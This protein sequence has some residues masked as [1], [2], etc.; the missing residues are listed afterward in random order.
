MN[1]FISMNT[2]LE[3]KNKFSDSNKMINS[4]NDE[5]LSLFKPSNNVFIN[6][7]D[8]INENTLTELNDNFLQKNQNNYTNE[9]SSPLLYDRNIVSTR[10]NDIDDI[11]VSTINSNTSNIPPSPS[12]NINN[13]IKSTINQTKKQNDLTSEI[14]LKNNKMY[15]NEIELEKKKIENQKNQLLIVNK[16]LQQKQL[17]LTEIETNFKKKNNEIIILKKQL[18]DQRNHY[19]NETENLKKKQNTYDQ[20][21]IQKKTEYD[22]NLN[23]LKEQQKKNQLDRNEIQSQ[24]S[25]LKTKNQSIEENEKKLEIEQ[26]K[27]KLYFNKLI[28]EKSEISR[29]YKKNLVLQKQISDTLSEKQKIEET[30]SA[31]I[32]LQDSQ[33][34]SINIEKNELDNKKKEYEQTKLD[35]NKLITIIKNKIE[36]ESIDDSVINMFL[37]RNN[38][39]YKNDLSKMYIVLKQIKDSLKNINKSS[40]SENV[41]MTDNIILDVDISTDNVSGDNVSSDNVSNDNVL[42]DNISGDNVSGDNVSSDNVSGDNVS[43]DNVSGDKLSIDY[44]SLPN[45]F[46]EKKNKLDTI[47][48]NKNV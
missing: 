10:L 46:E 3:M 25:L 12:S 18:I 39:F 34:E 37:D 2:R 30:I 9:Q 45:E 28:K 47:V 24:L 43:G 23:N 17:K 19:L 36:D 32:E 16:N 1:N 5:D 22:I 4:R 14:L 31:K 40:K 21:I 29:I 38:I 6:F 7:Q 26:N 41:T 13:N 35:R 44:K 27:H 8:K 33:L 15:L 42:G 48:L 20:L 11:S